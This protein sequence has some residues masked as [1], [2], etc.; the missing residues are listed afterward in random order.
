MRVILYAPT[1]RGD[2]MTKARH[3]EDLDLG[4]LARTLGADHV[5]LLRRHPAARRQA[6]AVP[7]REGFIIDVSDYPEVNELML[8]SDVLLT[9]Y[10]SV[11][12]EFALLER[13]MAFFAPDADAYER[14]RGFYFDYRATMPGPVFET[15]DALA[16]YLR[17]GSF[18]LARVESFSK[19]WF[20]VADG[21][22][23]ERFVERVVV[24]AL[25]RRRVV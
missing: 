15:T 23:S 19:T 4:L 1:F 7:G 20:E 10:S 3:P 21:H 12:F 8:V 25:E 24:P 5:L 16:A 9:D 6:L 11:A 17:A 14:E 2:D 22:A 13:P 18:D